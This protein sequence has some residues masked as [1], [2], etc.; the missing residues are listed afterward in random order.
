M[1]LCRFCVSGQHALN[2][3][4][5]CEHDPATAAGLDSYLAREVADCTC[6]YDASE[7]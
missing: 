6:E 5:Q 7:D 1:P 3:D 2:R 4:G